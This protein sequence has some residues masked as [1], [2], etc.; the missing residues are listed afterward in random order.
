MKAYCISGIGANEKVFEQLTLKFQYTTIKW[1]PTSRKESLEDYAKKLCEQIDTSEPFILIGVSYGG[2]LATE[3]N[4]FINP[5][6]TFLISSLAMRA[7]L[8][9]VLR[10]IGRIKLINIVPSFFFTVPPFIIYWF[11]GIHTQQ[12][13]QVI[14]DIIRGI[15]K[16]FTKLS[17]KKILEWTNTDIAENTVRIHG[18]K[19]RLLP[20]PDNVEFL[21]VKNGGHFMIGNR[22][23]EVS[24]LINEQYDL[25]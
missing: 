4:K 3:M 10:I 12:G 23:A 6:K 2:M 22:S 9:L 25:I 24:R 21:E 18:T 16:K 8:P 7:E 14:R 17:I 15:D 5:K 1:V 11:F 20:V 19:D 13:R